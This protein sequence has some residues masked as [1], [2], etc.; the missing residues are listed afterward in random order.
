M[1]TTKQFNARAAESY[2]TVNDPYDKKKQVDY[3]SRRYHGRQ[4]QTTRGKEGQTEG[5][6]TPFT[7]KTDVYHAYN[8][9]LKKQP[10]NTRKLGF[11]SFDARRRDEFMLDIRAQ[12]YKE[13][14]RQEY[15]YVSRFAKEAAQREDEAAAA[16]ADIK[17]PPRQYEAPRD[18]SLPPLFQTQVTRHLY[19]IGKD[20][21][22]TP[23]CTRCARETFYCPHRVGRGAETLRRKGLLNT[24]AEVYGSGVRGATKP[25]HGRRSHIKEFFDRNHL[26]VTGS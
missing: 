17:P 12:Q 13:L 9:Y 7:Y 19:D 5:Y 22:V 24:S 16:G 1:Y 11:G 20:G 3:G 4:F 25:E 23:I 8:S 26:H 2:I 6:F 18:P 10:R 14:L 21:G 15:G